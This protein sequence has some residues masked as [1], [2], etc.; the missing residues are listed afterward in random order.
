MHNS[1]HIPSEN[2]YYVKNNDK[3]SMGSSM[4]RNH[5]QL[6]MNKYIQEAK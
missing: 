1:A 4:K 2:K 3:S 5:K 6:E